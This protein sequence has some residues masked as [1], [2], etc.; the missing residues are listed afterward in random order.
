MT[1]GEETSTQF[2]KRTRPLIETAV[3]RAVLAEREA[4]AKLAE[5]WEGATHF[6]AND[7][8]RTVAL[9]IR[10]RGD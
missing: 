3:R 1:D 4:C 2:V 6:P 8:G 5:E 10:E 9:A 7:A